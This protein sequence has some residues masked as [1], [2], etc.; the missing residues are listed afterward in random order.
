MRD[1]DR[2]Q[3]KKMLVDFYSKCNKAIG[4]CWFLKNFYLFWLCWVFIAGCWL[5]LVELNRGHSL[6]V[7]H[8]LFTVVA[9]LAAEQRLPR[10]CQASVVATLSGLVAPLTWDLPGPGIKL[11]SSVLADR[12]LT[13]GP[14]GNSSYWQ[15]LSWEVQ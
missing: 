2:L 6:V 5:S 9:S 13:T 7:M 1:L 8:G 15:F 4:R 12:F 11:V 3:M 14:P 10:A